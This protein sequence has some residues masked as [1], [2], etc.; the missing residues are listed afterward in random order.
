M[1]G[2]SAQAR[3]IETLE[4]QYTEICDRHRLLDE[5]VADLRARI[6]SLRG[7][8][9]RVMDMGQFELPESVR[10]LIKRA[11]DCYYMIQ[12]LWIFRR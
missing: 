5:T 1:R 8:T 11:A 9:D 2:Y 10:E 12:G 6:E 7:E 3:G 4:A